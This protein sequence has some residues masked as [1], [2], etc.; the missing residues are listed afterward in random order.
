[1][2]LIHSRIEVEV[3]SF[4]ARGYPSVLEWLIP[5][6]GCAG[7]WNKAR[8]WSEVTR[9]LMV[10]GRKYVEPS[11]IIQGGIVPLEWLLG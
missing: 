6:R 11:V 10:I 4:T 9:E 1:M 7:A 2:C 8:R 3:G 5:S